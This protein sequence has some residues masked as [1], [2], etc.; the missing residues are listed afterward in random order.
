MLATQKWL[1]IV[2][3]AFLAGS[4]IASLELRA[5]AANTVFSTDIVDGQVKTADLAANSITAVKIKDA[6]VRAAEI[7][8]NAVGSNEIAPDAV[9][10]SELQGVSK[11]LFGQCISTESQRTSATLPG[12]LWQVACTITGVDAD[13]SAVA[14]LNNQ[15]ASCFEIAHARTGVNFVAVEVRN[16]CS[17][18]TT[19]GSASSI[20]VIVYDK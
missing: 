6:E 4:F 9:G 2:A 14:T 17:F 10:G 13:D 5:F 1:A 8:S 19:L 12:F 15:A 16:D 3:A 11:L 18:S 20:A 7:A